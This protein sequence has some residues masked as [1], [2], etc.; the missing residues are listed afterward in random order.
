MSDKINR[1]NNPECNKE[2]PKDKK[3]CNEDCLKRHLELKKHSK[4]V[5][6]A[7]KDVIDTSNNSTIIYNG[8][9]NALKD[10][11]FQS[12]IKW[13]EGKLK[14]I[15]KAR[16]NGLTDLQILKELRISGITSHK[17]IELMSE[18][19]ELLGR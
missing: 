5:T 3:Y 19:E 9:M 7:N 11:S 8:F 2:I 6:D 1:C 4:Q 14:A 17:A 18:S 13:R 10:Q 16:Q 12:G 15:L